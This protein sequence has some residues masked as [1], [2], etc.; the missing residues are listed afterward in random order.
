LLKTAAQVIIVLENKVTNIPNPKNKQNLILENIQD[1]GNLGT[2]IRTA[3]WFG[4]ENIFCSENT[5]ELTNP[6]VLQ[7]TMGSFLRVN[8][9]YVILEKGPLVHSIFNYPVSMTFFST[10]DKLEIGN[11]PFISRNAKPTRDEALEYY[12]RVTLHFQ[13]NVHLYE[14]VSTIKKNTHGF[15]IETSK[16][17]FYARFIIVATGFYDIPNL[18][19]VPGE[20][21]PKVHHYYKDPHLYFK[22]KIV[23]VGSAN[24]AVDAALETYRKGSEVTMV[25]REPEIQQNVKYWVRPDIVNRIKEGSINAWFNSSI[26]E[27]SENEVIISTPEGEI[28]ISNDFV[29]AMTGYMPDFSFLQQMGIEIVEK[30]NI[31]LPNHNPDTLES[32]V[33]GI[34]LAGVICGGS[35]TNKW[36]IEN[37][38][39]HAPIITEEIKKRLQLTIV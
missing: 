1:P 14:N 23:V 6:K 35:Q 37:S 8:I 24:S 34:F 39:I 5:V 27:I 36:F 10:S 21:L 25:I 30:D 20:N 2:I 3:D 4:I 12:R 31:V 29:L 32:N 18:L 38:R 16:S 9:S 7:A 28:H 26:K 11:V 13:L 17:K 33:A 19:G 15:Y 22:Q